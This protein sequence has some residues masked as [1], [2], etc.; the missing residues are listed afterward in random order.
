MAIQLP[1][2]HIWQSFLVISIDYFVISLSSR[3]YFFVL[4][5]LL[6]AALPAQVA[7]AQTAPP[8]PG[9][10][11]K[12]Q[13]LAYTV[14]DTT[15]AGPPT[16]VRGVGGWLTL[17]PTGTYKKRLSITGNNGP[18]WFRQDGTFTLTGD[19]IRFA[20]T[21]LKGAD[22][23]RGTFRFDPT[24]RHLT[25]TVLG[26]PTGNRGVYELEAAAVPAPAPQPKARPRKARNEGHR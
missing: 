18:I 9:I 16:E 15:T 17:R 23:Q 4:S 1:V 3:N 25:V 14:Y 24:T 20:F 7:N 6:L 19:S 12:Y 21:D 2:P 26:Y 10:F 22:V 8:E 11:T 13:Y 5:A